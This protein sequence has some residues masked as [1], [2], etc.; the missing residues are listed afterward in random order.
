M[1]SCSSSSNGISY[2]VGAVVVAVVVMLVV[3][4][5]ALEI[6]VLVDVSTAAVSG[7]IIQRNKTRQVTVATNKLT[8]FIRHHPFSRLII[9]ANHPR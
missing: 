1:Y 2:S 5:V 6:V 9:R 8:D 3:V 4:A 7:R